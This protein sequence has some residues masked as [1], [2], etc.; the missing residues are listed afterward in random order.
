MRRG[1]LPSQTASP[2]GAPVSRNLPL[3]VNRSDASAGLLLCRSTRLVAHCPVGS[4]HPRLHHGDR[5][6][7]LVISKHA[8]LTDN[9]QPGLAAQFPRPPRALQLRHLLSNTGQHSFCM[10]S[11]RRP[12]SHALPSNQHSRQAIKRAGGNELGAGLAAK[13]HSRHR[14]CMAG[15]DADGLALPHI[16]H[17]HH[18]VEAAAGLRGRVMGGDGDGVPS[19]L[20]PT[21]ACVSTAPWEQA[22]RLEGGSSSSS[23][24]SSGAP[25]CRSPAGCRR[26]S[27]RST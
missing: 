1:G 6:G 25:P 2:W 8:T 22:S 18:L 17:N 3:G 14:V 12:V 21:F 10:A 5:E 20:S 19:E 13:S 16:P 15:D 4:C 9:K 24:S 7:W 27:R 11:C 23:S 26:H